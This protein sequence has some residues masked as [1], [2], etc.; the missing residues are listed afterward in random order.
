MEGKCDWIEAWMKKGTQKRKQWAWQM[1][2]DCAKALRYSKVGLFERQWKAS[3]AR[4]EI[5]TQSSHAQAFMKILISN[6]YLI[7]L[8]LLACGRVFS[9]HYWVP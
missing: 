9:S 4:A 2:T 7:I 6:K 8:E 1:C 5:E 3:V